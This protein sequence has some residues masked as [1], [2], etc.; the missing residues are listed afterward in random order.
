MFNSFFSIPGLALLALMSIAVQVNPVFA[1]SIE[2]EWQQTASNKEEGLSQFDQYALQGDFEAVLL[3]LERRD[4]Y[5]PSGD[6]STVTN[7]DHLTIGLQYYAQLND[8]Y[9]LWPRMQ[10]FAGY[11][12]H[13]ASDSV[14]Y[15]PQ[16]V[17]IKRLNEDLSLVAGAGAL[18]HTSENQYYPVVGVVLAP[19]TGSRWSGN[20]TVPQG[21]IAYQIS[22]R[23]FAEAGL[24]WQTRYYKTDR[25]LSEAAFMRTR[26]TL[27]SLGARVNLNTQL[28]MHGGINYAFD[29]DVRLY[30]GISGHRA[31]REPANGFGFRLAVAYH[32]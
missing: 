11:D 5:V 24:K 9:A 10:I 13:V 21:D 8:S 27:I 15:N 28:R 26:D 20:L 32:F 12:D 14:T 29:R 25:S 4:Y 17:G 1:Q 22:E 6:G 30:D 31:T 23:W 16:L 7:L 2:L 19:S 18:I 3:G